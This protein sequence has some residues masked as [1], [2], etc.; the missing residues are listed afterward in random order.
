MVFYFKEIKMQQA[1]S[2][3]VLNKKNDKVLILKR[4][5]HARSNTG[6]WNFPGGGVESEESVIEAAIRE[7]KEETAL[8]TDKRDL[9]KI[10]EKQYDNWNVHYFVALT[11]KGDVLLNKESLDYKW[12]NPEK[13]NTIDFLAIPEHLIGAIQGK[14]ICRPK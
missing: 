9:I 5:S 1:A 2:I 13:I 6:I 12:V 3:I 11:Y 7:L 14:L 10:C 8:A 4:S